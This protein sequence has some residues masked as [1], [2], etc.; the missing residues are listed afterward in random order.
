MEQKCLE[1]KLNVANF[2]M[3]ENSFIFKINKSKNANSI[4][5][6]YFFNLSL[7]LEKNRETFNENVKVCF[8][9]N[10]SLANFKKTLLVIHI[11]SFVKLNLCHNTRFYL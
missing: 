8:I 11:I 1:F 10:I 4:Q 3:F 9:K 6:Q 5:N 2:F 7:L